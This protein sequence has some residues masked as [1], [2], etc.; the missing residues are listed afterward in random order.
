MRGGDYT[1][2]Y[3][4]TMHVLDQQLQAI[5]RCLARHEAHALGGPLLVAVSGGQD[6][7]VLVW[8]LSELHRRGELSAGL[9]IGHVDHGVHELSAA[10]ATHVHRLAEQLKLP[11]VSTRLEGVGTSE[12]ALRDARYQRLVEMAR[13]H[14]ARMVLTAHHAD[15]DMET[16]LFRMMR[17]TGPRGLAGIP[18]FRPLANGIAVLRPLLRTRQSTIAR[19]LE[20]SGLTIFEDPTNL[21]LA[22]ARNQLRHELIPDLREVLGTRLDMSLIALART[23]RAANDI[24]EA[25]ATRMLRNYA[26]HPTSWRCDLELAP[27]RDEDLPFLEEAICQ[28]HAQLHPTGRRPSVDFGRRI[29]ALWKQPAGRRVHGPTELLAER[30]RTGILIV[31]LLLA[32]SPPVDR[33]ELP[34]DELV[35]FGSTEWGVRRIR[36]ASPPMSPT[37][38]EAGPRRG[39]VR[40]TF[41]AEPWSLR[42][43]RAGD[44]FWPLGARGP[45]ELRRFLQARHVPRFDRDRLPI[46]VDGND[47][48]LW[49]PG[50]EIAAPHRIT[51]E[52]EACFEV[53]LSI[54]GGAGESPGPY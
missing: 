52:T 17:G 54:L 53:K 3:R 28:V 42:P 4:P 5:R 2:P 33:V 16:V 15:D 37:P 6:S 36:H 49:V 44:R 41:A 11:V 19:L 22:Y 48:I 29:L 38:T 26:S 24:L 50:V 47:E 21:D 27:P 25:Q 7:T 23:A 13:D 46:L 39:L 31:D 9:V 30:T 40:A 8:L 20:L 14:G 34:T 12:E 1:G 45:V 18:E 43:R 10:A 35:R 32:G 51:V